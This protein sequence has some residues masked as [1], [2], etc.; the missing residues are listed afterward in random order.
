LSPRHWPSRFAIHR[1]II[2]DWL[3]A[4]AMILL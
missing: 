2:L 4:A 1:I 3:R